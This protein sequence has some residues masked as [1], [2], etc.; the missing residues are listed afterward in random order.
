MS[1]REKSRP[2]FII[3][4]IASMRLFLAKC[5]KPSKNEF[6]LL[7][8]S[9]AI[10]IGFLGTIGYVIKLIHIPINNIIVNKQA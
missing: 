9:H 6:T 5:V 7:L 4:S 1:T 3:S 2:S 8:R 10:G